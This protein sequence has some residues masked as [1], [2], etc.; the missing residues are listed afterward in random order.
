MSKVALARYDLCECLNRDQALPMK[1]VISQEIKGGE[2]L[3]IIKY[4]CP[5]CGFTKTVVN[6]HG[7][8]NVTQAQYDVALNS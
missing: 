1:E 4:T 8:R 2:N 5:A 7:K 3:E 6:T